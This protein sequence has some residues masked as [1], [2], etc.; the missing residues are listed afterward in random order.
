MNAHVRIFL[1]VN[2][3][4]PGPPFNKNLGTRL[5]GQWFSAPDSQAFN[6]GRRKI[7]GEEVDYRRG[8]PVEEE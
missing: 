2:S 6:N 8:V 4:V 3:L 7:P 5:A 1:L